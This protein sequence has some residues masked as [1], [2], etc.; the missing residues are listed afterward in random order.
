MDG[1]I[2][3]K[4]VRALREQRAWSQ[5]HLATVS[6]LSLRTVQR[7]EGVGRASAESRLALAAVLEVEATDL[8]PEP[9]SMPCDRRRVLG[10]RLPWLALLGVLLGLDYWGDAHLSWSLWVTGGM[11]LGLAWRAWRRAVVASG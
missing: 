2:N 1:Q 10:R 9:T 5:Q 3:A 4:M 6:G 7:I 8:L 11:L